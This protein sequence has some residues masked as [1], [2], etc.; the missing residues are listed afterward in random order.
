MKYCL[1]VEDNHIEAFLLQRIL[2]KIGYLT[3]VTDN[4]FMAVEM[5]RK[6]NVDVIATDISMPGISGLELIKFIRMEDKKIPIVAVTAQVREEV[7]V[8][9]FQNGVNYYIVK[10]YTD[11]D[12]REVFSQFL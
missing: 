4:V 9:A 12:I 5:A 7:R 3:T 2:I 1:I 6:G 8:Q 10:P 11:K